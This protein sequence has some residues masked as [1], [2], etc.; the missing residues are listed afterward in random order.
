MTDER[1][2]AEVHDDHVCTEL[3][4]D[5]VADLRELVRAKDEPWE[6]RRPHPTQSVARRIEERNHLLKDGIVAVARAK[7]LNFAH[8]RRV[9]LRFELSA[10][11]YDHEEHAD[12]E[13]HALAVIDLIHVR[14]PLQHVREQRL[15][16]TVGIHEESKLAERA[17]DIAQDLT[18][19]ADAREAALAVHPDRGAASRQRRC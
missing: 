10:A 18:F 14:E 9:E 3:G 13:V 12:D 7:G 5:G 1:R 15:S 2:C 6:P 4:E 8:E 17:V 19:N 16:C 11:G